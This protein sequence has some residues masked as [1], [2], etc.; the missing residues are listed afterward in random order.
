MR[1]REIVAPVSGGS[2]NVVTSVRRRH[3]RG[4]GGQLSQ[5]ERAAKIAFL[6]S[7]FLE[8]HLVCKLGSDFKRSLTRALSF[9]TNFAVGGIQ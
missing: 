2:G 7:G 1:S 4:A 3:R 8:H 5:L 6:R 9:D